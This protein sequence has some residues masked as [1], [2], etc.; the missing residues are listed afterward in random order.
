MSLHG[1]NG[2]GGAADIRGVQATIRAGAIGAAQTVQPRFVLPDPVQMERRPAFP[3]SRS[4]DDSSP[5]ER[6]SEAFESRRG[7]GR[8]EAQAFTAFIAQSIAQEL[9]LAEPSLRSSSAILAGTGAYA[10]TAAAGP[11]Q[12]GDEVEIIPPG[13]FSGQGL[14]LIA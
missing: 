2:L 12:G 8:G 4:S 13:R 5:G 9:D 10:R 6:P 1:I 14:D 11:R 3:R 7:G